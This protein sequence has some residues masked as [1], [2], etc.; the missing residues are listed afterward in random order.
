MANGCEALMF[1]PSFYVG[2]MERGRILYDNT[3]ALVQEMR[4]AGIEHRCDTPEDDTNVFDT[5][6][7]GWQ[8]RRLPRT[9]ILIRV[10]DRGA[11]LETLPLGE[12]DPASRARALEEVN[13]LNVEYRWLKLAI[14]ESGEL[15]CSSDV[16]LVPEVA[17]LFG[18]AAM[19]RMF[20]ALDEMY[21]RFVG[22]LR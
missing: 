18:I 5:V 2:I 10:N 9:T 3:K 15:V 19:G 14:G 21:P 22:L 4:A 1:L 20:D 16:F 7:V 12:V 11:H 17:G 13:A 6:R 8:G